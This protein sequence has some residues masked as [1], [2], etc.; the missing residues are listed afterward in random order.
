[1]QCI[2]FYPEFFRFILSIDE[3]NL[4]SNLNLLSLRIV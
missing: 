3:L 4:I 2:N 1:M